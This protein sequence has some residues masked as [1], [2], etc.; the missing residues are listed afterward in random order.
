[1]MKSLSDSLDGPDPARG[2]LLL[3]GDHVPTRWSSRARSVSLIPLLPD[4]VRG[5]LEDGRA[6]SGLEEDDVALARLVARG[7]SIR[8]IVRELGVSQRS[9]ER[10]LSRLRKQ[11]GAASKGELSARLAERGFGR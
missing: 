3:D 7:L 6:T 4:E 9:V 10:R 11:M 5:V 1:M 8:A 2:W